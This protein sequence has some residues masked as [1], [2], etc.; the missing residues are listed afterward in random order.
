MKFPIIRSPHLN[1]I[2]GVFNAELV[3]E[4]GV[5]CMS[6]PGEIYDALRRDRVL[7]GET[8]HTYLEPRSRFFATS[9]RELDWSD[10]EMDSW[11]KGLELW[12]PSLIR[13][14]PEPK[15]YAF[16]ARIPSVDDRQ[17]P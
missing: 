1:T 2:K 5:E 17:G 9:F 8:L 16:G 6:M 4:D 3:V 15:Q 12:A 13:E 14:Y 7:N 11:Y 10:A